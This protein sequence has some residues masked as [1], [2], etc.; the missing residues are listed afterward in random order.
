MTERP[1]EPLWK[2]Q[3]E[4]GDYQSCQTVTL[5]NPKCF[6]PCSC[7]LLVMPLRGPQEHIKQAEFM[8]TLMVLSIKHQCMCKKLGADLM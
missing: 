8:I 7:T 4:K 1:E 6:I 3:Q 2:F 5:E